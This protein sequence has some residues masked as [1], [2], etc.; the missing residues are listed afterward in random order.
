MNLKWFKLLSLTCLIMTFCFIL[1]NASVNALINDWGTSWGV[2]PVYPRLNK[3]IP[4]SA[5]LMKLAM[6]EGKEFGKSNKVNM[7]DDKIIVVIMID[8][9]TS[10]DVHASNIFGVGSSEPGIVNKEVCVNKIEIHV[11]DEGS[12]VSEVRVM[13]LD[14]NICHTCLPSFQNIMK[15]CV[16]DIPETSHSITILFYTCNLFLITCISVESS[17]ILSIQTWRMALRRANWD[18]WCVLSRLLGIQ[19]PSMIPQEDQE[20][21]QGWCCTRWQS[22]QLWPGR[23]SDVPESPSEFYPQ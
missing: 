23:T 3:T 20:P 6:L 2:K 7:M 4:S 16:Q 14:I 5:S 13:F 9:I 10:F 8:F 12:G 22:G 11:I 18:Y 17:C 15:Y 1:E 21:W 19:I